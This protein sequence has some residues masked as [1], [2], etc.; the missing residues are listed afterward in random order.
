MS[1]ELKPY[2]KENLTIKRLRECK[3]SRQYLITQLN[4]TERGFAR[5]KKTYERDVKVYAEE[6]EKA[7][8]FMEILDQKI[9]NYSEQL[10]EFLPKPKPKVEKVDPKSVKEEC[11]YCGKKYAKSGIKSH[12]KACLKKIELAK[13]QKE[14]DKLELEDTL[15]ELDKK[16]DAEIIEVVE[17]IIDDL[18]DSI[19]LDK[20]TEDVSFIG[21][22]A[23]EELPEA[24][25][26]NPKE[27]EGD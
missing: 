18:K 8:D 13:L 15:E 12:Q 6:I 17:D 26:T 19:D 5:C 25:Y 20:L 4:A 11:K 1:K 10:K 3:N 2:E 23:K 7:K 9:K 24:E 22:E 21:I 14:I 27:E 16:E